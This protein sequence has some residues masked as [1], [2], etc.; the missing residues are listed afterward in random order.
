MKILGI[1]S[2]ILLLVLGALIAVGLDAACAL[3]TAPGFYLFAI[4][5]I[6][7]ALLAWRERVLQFSVVAYVAVLIALPFLTLSPVKPFR[8]FY[9]LVENG[10]TETEVS[11]ILAEQFPVAGNFPR[12][13]QSRTNDGDLWFRLDPNDGAYN[14]ELVVVKMQNGRAVSKEYLP[15]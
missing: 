2:A 1:A 15:D 13:V 9:S 12:P 5:P 14:A 8:S 10:M 3:S 6:L 11:A 7:P 4:V